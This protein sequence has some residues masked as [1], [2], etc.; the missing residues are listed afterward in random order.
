MSI[1]LLEN[2]MSNMERRAILHGEKRVYPR[3][4]DLHAAVTAI[5][6]KVELV[7]EG[8]QQGAAIVARKIIGEAV[9]ETFRRRFPDPTPKK[10][11]TSRLG[12]SPFG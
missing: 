3:I 11:K 12:A 9:K 10:K 4:G 2:V 7:Y 6:G 8:E 1:S 5:T